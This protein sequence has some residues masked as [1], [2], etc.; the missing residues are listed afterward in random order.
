[1]QFPHIIRPQQSKRRSS[2]RGFSVFLSYCGE[3]A[4]NS[5]AQVQHASCIIA[6]VKWE[7]REERRLIFF[8]HRTN[9]VHSLENDR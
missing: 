1:M 5:V 2:A 7:K 4:D 9:I 6:R 3:M 8:L